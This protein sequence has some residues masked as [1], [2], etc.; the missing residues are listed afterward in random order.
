MVRSPPRV[1]QENP[2]NV[3]R[4]SGGLRGVRGASRRARSFL[5]LG[6]VDEV[7]AASAVGDGA[8]DGLVDFGIE[9][10]GHDLIGRHHA[11]DGLGGGDEHARVQGAGPR[12]Q[13]TFEDAGEGERIVNRS[14]IGGVAGA[15]FARGVGIDPACGFD[16]A[17]MTWPCGSS[18]A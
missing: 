8:T 4:T 9:R 15:G 2:V 16:S 10:G 17:K 12:L 11:G 7:E 3:S 1:T 5:E 14:A 13:R 18:R 6:G